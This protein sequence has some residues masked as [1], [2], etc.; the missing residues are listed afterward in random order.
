MAK[1]AVLLEFRKWDKQ[2]IT[3]NA[4]PNPDDDM[5]HLFIR[6]GIVP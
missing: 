5:F 3:K 1:S 2:T 4:E 6:Q